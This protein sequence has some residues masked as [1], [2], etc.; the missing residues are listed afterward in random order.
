MVRFPIATYIAPYVERLRIDHGRRKSP[1]REA[2]FLI[3]KEEAIKS[4]QARVPETI[5]S[6]FNKIS[7]DGWIPDSPRD[8]HYGHWAWEIDLENKGKKPVIR[9]ATRPIPMFSAPT[10]RERQPGKPTA[11]SK[12]SGVLHDRAAMMLHSILDKM[13]A[14][15]GGMKLT[16]EDVKAFAGVLQSIAY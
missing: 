13:A 6:Q 4:F 10:P 3:S 9:C 11:F 5:L 8:T 12:R 7:V 15:E 14:R 2:A 16:R 1:C